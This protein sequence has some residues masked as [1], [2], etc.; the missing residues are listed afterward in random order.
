MI[1]ITMNNFSAP[2]PTLIA[3]KYHIYMSYQNEG[4]SKRSEFVGGY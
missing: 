3:E 1:L 4:I 2:T